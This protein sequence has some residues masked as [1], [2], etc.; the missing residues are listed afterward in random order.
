VGPPAVVH[1]AGVPVVDI[2][3]LVPSTGPIGV[4]LSICSYAGRLRVGVLADIAV[5]PDAAV[6]VHALDDELAAAGA[7]PN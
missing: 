3:P 2:V 7:P 4:G 1:L 5:L 6:L